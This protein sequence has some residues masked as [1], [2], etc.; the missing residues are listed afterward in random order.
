MPIALERIA[1]DQFGKAVG[2]VCVGGMNRAHFTES[3]VEV[4][5]RQLPGGFGSGET[6]ADDG[7]VA[8]QIL[9]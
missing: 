3:D 9:F 6:A 4:P 2:L 1:A 8:L 7:D 5:L